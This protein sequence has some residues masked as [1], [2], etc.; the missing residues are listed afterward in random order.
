MVLSLIHSSST[1]VRLFSCLKHRSDYP[2]LLA[3]PEITQNNQK[4]PVDGKVYEPTVPR[5]VAFIM[6]GNGRWAEQRGLSR[7]EGHT[8]GASATV[9]VVKAVFDMGVEVV[10][11]YLFS[12]GWWWVLGWICH[13]FSLPPY[14]PPYHSIVFPPFVCRTYPYPRSLTYNLPLPLPLL[15]P[16]RELETST[17]RSSQH[18]VITSF[19]ALQHDHIFPRQPCDYPCDW[20]VLE[21]AIVSTRRTSVIATTPSQLGQ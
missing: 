17:C 6:D 19:L 9:E 1:H 21:I 20:P 2:R 18:Y 10:T 7:S 8:A 15:P 3:S 16:P 13:A 14:L 4:L 11:L 12:T 5:H